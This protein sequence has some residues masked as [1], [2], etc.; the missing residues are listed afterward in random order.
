[1]GNISPDC[2]L[3]RQNNNPSAPGNQQNAQ[4]KTSGPKAT[5]EHYGQGEIDVEEGSVM[6]G[7][8]LTHLA[9]ILFSSKVHG[10][11]HQCERK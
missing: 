4:K 1:M 7:M 3:P 11:Y 10:M 6:L 2:P 5:R 8:Y 9:V